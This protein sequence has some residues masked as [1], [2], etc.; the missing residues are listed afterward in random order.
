[1]DVAEYFA[2]GDSD[3]KMPEVYREIRK[4][5]AKI[6]C[7]YNVPTLND[8]LRYWF[9]EGLEKTAWDILKQKDIK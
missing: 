5:L 4:I 2:A 8:T 9:E 1:M 7:E 6:Y 3:F